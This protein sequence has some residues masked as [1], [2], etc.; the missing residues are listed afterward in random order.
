M[1]PFYVLE[2]IPLAAWIAISSI[3]VVGAC[4]VVSVRARP[5]DLV[6]NDPAARVPS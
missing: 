5:L 6:P 3:G 4:F 1:L 2:G